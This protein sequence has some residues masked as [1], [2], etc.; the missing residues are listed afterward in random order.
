MFVGA[1]LSRLI[2]AGVSD[3]LNIN[4]MRGDVLA[5]S[6]NVLAVLLETLAPI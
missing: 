3:T 5:L 6:A 4:C 2:D 1:S